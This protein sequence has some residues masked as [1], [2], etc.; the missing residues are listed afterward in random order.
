MERW[1][2]GWNKGGEAGW[3]GRRG[4]LSRLRL[5]FGAGALGEPV[6]A[7]FAS[8]EIAFLF[9]FCLRNHRG[10]GDRLASFIQGDE[11]EIRGTGVESDAGHEVFG[12]DPHSD[13]H[14][15]AKYP[16]DRGVQDNQLADMNGLQKV[17]T[18]D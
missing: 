17:Q 3:A 12:E 14:R 6:F 13:F 8:L 2:E 15:C 9:F 18:I 16:V 7:P 5:W 4:D 11:S 10:N 1:L